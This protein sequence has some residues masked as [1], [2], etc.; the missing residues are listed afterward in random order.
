LGA[1]GKRIEVQGR[2]QAV[3][4]ALVVQPDV[5]SV[6]AARLNEMDLKEQSEIK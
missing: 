5:V 6:A 2:W 4:A 3:S 1:A